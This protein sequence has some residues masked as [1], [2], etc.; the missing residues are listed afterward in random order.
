MQTSQTINTCGL[1]KEMAVTC[2]LIAPDT[3]ERVDALTLT[4]GNI[5]V[6]Q[7]KVKLVDCMPRLILPG[8]LAEESIVRS[9][10]V[11]FGTGLKSA[12]ED[13]KLIR[14]L[15]KNQHTSPLESVKFT[16]AIRCPKFV[17]IQ[18]IRHRTANINEFSQRYA[19]IDEDLYHKPSVVS[20]GIRMQCPFNKQSSSGEKIPEGK[21]LL[22]KE[23]VR[24]TEDLLDQVL[25]KYHELVDLGVAK[26]IARFC[27][28]M[29]IY[30]DL[31]Y[32]MDLNN[33]LKFLKLR[34]DEHAQYETRVFAQAML[35]LIRP[36]VPTVLETAGL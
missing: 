6:L 24:E 14:Y 22:I 28:P 17:A 16:F 2:T 25:V 19:E 13:Q 34:V 27:L 31:Y 32:T 21:E 36:L 26:E 8:H 15:V 3:L 30:T 9:A 7:G 33:L 12:Q 29:G 11:S 18:L 1:A 10:R 20:N 4:Q 23:K 35:D 5:D